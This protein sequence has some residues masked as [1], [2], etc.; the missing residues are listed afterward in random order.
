M[1]KLH[2]DH[3][4][5]TW[6]RDE[7]HIESETPYDSFAAAIDDFLAITPEPGQKITL[8]HG[9]RIIRTKIGEAP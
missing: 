2:V 7:M 9:A 1:G 6:T 3:R 5:V 8:Q 4:I